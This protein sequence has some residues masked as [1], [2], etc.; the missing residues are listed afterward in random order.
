MTDK[1]K[2]LLVLDQ[3][4][5]ITNLLEGNEYESYLYSRLITVK[6]EIERQLTNLNHSANILK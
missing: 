6:Y 5:N 3:V 2:L 4:N 1:I